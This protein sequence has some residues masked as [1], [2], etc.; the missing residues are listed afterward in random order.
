MEIPRNYLF[1]K[2]LK[3]RKKNL[4]EVENRHFWRNTILR[5]VFRFGDFSAHFFFFFFQKNDIFK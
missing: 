2:S 5:I 1:A 3:I 4:L